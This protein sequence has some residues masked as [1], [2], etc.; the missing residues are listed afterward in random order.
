MVVHGEFHEQ[1]VHYE[2]RRLAGVIDSGLT[3]LDSRPYELA[4]AR[5]YRAPGTI[6]AYRG[7]LARSG[8]PSANSRRPPSGPSATPSVST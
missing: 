2:H 6:A 3:H 8:C 7:E 1:N 4:I 5:T